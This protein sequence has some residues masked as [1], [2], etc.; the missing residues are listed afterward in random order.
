MTVVPAS[1]LSRVEMLMLGHS[2][3]PRARAERVD[4]SAV[5]RSLGAHGEGVDGLV[6]TASQGGAAGQ[7][8]AEPG[9]TP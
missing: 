4:L 3:A 6:E 7:G 9:M 5:N 8:V 1:R 2:I